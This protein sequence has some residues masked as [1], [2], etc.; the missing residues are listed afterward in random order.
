MAMKDE[1]QFTIGIS[2]GSSNQIAA[3]VVPLLVIIG[4]LTGDDLTLFFED[5]ETVLSLPASF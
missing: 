2:L 4:W 5:F 3:F 1:M